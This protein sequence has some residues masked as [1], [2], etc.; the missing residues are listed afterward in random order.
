LRLKRNIYLQ[1]R[2]GATATYGTG[3]VLPALWKV[4]TIPYLTKRCSAVTLQISKFM[5]IF[6]GTEQKINY[7]IMRTFLLV[8]NV[9]CTGRLT[10]KANVVYNHGRSSR[11]ADISSIQLL[12]GKL[13]SLVSPRVFLPDVSYG[14]HAPLPATK[15]SI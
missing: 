2:V 4:G 6:F 9:Y 13:R 12:V 15:K 8:F 3:T 5:Y 14:Y 11:S 1:L 7:R 10:R